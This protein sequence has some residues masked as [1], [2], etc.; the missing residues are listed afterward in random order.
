MNLEQ[1]IK[2]LKV[3]DPERY[4]SLMEGTTEEQFISDVSK[5]SEQI[6]RAILGVKK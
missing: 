5:Y 4:A 6:L 1:Y 2:D 3:T